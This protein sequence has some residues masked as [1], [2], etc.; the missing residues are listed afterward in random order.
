[1]PATE[2][3]LRYEQKEPIT[4]LNCI[5]KQTP[6]PVFIVG[7]PLAG[8]KRPERELVFELARRAAH[9][10]PERMLRYV[11]PQPA[12]LAHIIDAAMLM[13]EMPT[14]KGASQPNPT[15]EL[16]KTA[17]GFKRAL[18]PVQLEQVASVGRKL[19]AAG[20]KS[21]AAALA[22]LQTSDLTASRAGLVLAGDL[23]TC[24]RLLA[25]EAQSAS[26]LP[27]MQR[28]LDLVWSSVTEEMFA[29][30]KHLGLM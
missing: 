8:D 7:Q 12:Q 3:Y 24:A 22:W 5:D 6:V 30:R 16:A 18:T 4:F 21:E 25:A 9:L 27:A 28:L 11:L 2:T 14:E 20:V 19:R 26:S 15:G 23:E 17:Q 13:G 10:R 29:V 1:M